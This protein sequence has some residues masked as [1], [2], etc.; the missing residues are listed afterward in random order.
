M[1]KETE[2]R[3][4]LEF[5]DDVATLTITGSL[6]VESI[7]ELKALLMKA[8]AGAGRVRVRAESFTDMDMAILQ[9]L[10]STS[11]SASLMGKILDMEGE[12]LDEFLKTAESAGFSREM[13]IGCSSQEPELLEGV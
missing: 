1:A 13:L 6:N 3:N 9:L 4:I 11:Q 8:L 10:C 5:S 12:G 7:E 2:N